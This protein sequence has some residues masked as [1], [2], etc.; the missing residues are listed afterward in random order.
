MQFLMVSLRL[1]TNGSGSG[2][3]GGQS[4]KNLPRSLNVVPYTNSETVVPMSSFKEDRRPST[5]S[6]NLSTHQS[7]MRH[8]MTVFNG[9]CNRY[10]MLSSLGFN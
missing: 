10:N 8:L 9:L 3:E 7:V 6:G 1:H 4:P 2:S 5:T